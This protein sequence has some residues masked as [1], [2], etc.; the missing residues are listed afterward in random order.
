MSFSFPVSVETPSIRALALFG[1]SIKTSRAVGASLPA[2]W[3]SVRSVDL[4]QRLALLA[5][6]PRQKRMRLLFP[7]AS[8]KGRLDGSALRKR[9]V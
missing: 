4:E 9:F 7:M 3:P 8:G 2:E 6:P 5:A 1:Q